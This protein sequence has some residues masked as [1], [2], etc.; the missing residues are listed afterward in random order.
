M[1]IT[2]HRPEV[3]YKGEVLD[4]IEA[5]IPRIGALVTYYGTAVLGQLEMMCTSPLNES[6]SITRSRVREHSNTR[7]YADFR[8]TQHHCELRAKIPSP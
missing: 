2:S 7:H 5:V 6:V 1:N 4:D 8:C 3:H